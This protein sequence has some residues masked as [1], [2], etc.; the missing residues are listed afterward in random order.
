[1]VSGVLEVLP[2]AVR[3]PAPMCRMHGTEGRW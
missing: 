2:A 1:V 3:I